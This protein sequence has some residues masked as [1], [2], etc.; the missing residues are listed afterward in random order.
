MCGERALVG[1]KLSGRERI[2]AA[3]Q[4]PAVQRC[5]RQCL[6]MCS[7]SRMRAQ[8][9]C[10]ELAAT[11]ELDAYNASSLSSKHA[12]G[13]PSEQVRADP[14]CVALVISSEVQ[15]CYG[16]AHGRAH[17]HPVTFGQEDGSMD[18]QTGTDGQTDG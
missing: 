18:R 14:S 13:E 15:M 17:V 3:R 9:E 11:Q 6:L 2:Q 5:A 12:N 1:A 10:D 16:H 7:C 8:D 4:R